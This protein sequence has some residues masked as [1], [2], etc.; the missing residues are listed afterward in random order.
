MT[1]DD[2]VKQGYDQ[3]TKRNEDLEYVIRCRDCKHNPKESWFEC[4]MAHLSEAQRPDDAWCWKGERK[5]VED[6]S[7]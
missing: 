4:P 7:K 2:V 6:E 1:W 3:F 5:E